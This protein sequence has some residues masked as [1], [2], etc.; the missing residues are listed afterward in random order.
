MEVMMISMMLFSL[1]G[2]TLL[3]L[4]RIIKLKFIQHLPLRLVQGQWAC[5]VFWPWYFLAE[6][7]ATNKPKTTPPAIL[8]LRVT[9]RFVLR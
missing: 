6:A 4:F 7:E 9:L 3:K 8:I 2:L 1:F 5:L